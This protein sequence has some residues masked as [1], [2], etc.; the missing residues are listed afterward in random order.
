MGN[1]FLQ[2]ICYFIESIVTKLEPLAPANWTSLG[3]Q[4]LAWPVLALSLVLNQMILGSGT[5][6]SHQSGIRIFTL[7]PKTLL[8]TVACERQVEKTQESRGFLGSWH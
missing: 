7:K 3:H 1:A 5:I 4:A 8:E 2:V 6:I